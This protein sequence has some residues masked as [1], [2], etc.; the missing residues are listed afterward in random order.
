[1][2][3]ILTLFVAAV[4]VTTIAVERGQ[5]DSAS[6]S[7]DRVPVTVALCSSVACCVTTLSVTVSSAASAS[8]RRAR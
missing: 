5:R 6:L 7:Q 4:D 1:M 3:L 8:A 2:R